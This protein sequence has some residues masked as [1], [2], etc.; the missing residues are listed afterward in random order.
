MEIQGR[1]VKG[2]GLGNLYPS[3]TQG[4]ILVS[5][6]CYKK[7]HRLGDLNNTANSSG[8]WEVQAQGALLLS[9]R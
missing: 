2:M 8:G 7:Y 6:G 3:Q 4:S 9:P 5:S 1:R